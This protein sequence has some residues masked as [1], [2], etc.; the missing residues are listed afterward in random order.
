M[1]STTV[2]Y[3]ESPGLV[4]D[5]PMSVL[6]HIWQ[7]T[8]ERLALVET[9]KARGEKSK[10]NKKQ[11]FSLVLYATSRLEEIVDLH[12]VRVCVFPSLTSSKFSMKTLGHQP[13]SL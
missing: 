2:P 4:I 7:L 9:A 3:A 13:E 5:P 10:E 8:K 12:Q 6:W 11:Y 1:G